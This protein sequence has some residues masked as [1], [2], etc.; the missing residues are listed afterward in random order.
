RAVDGA[1]THDVVRP[2]HPDRQHRS[3]W[4]DVD[5]TVAIIRIAL[6]IFDVDDAP[7]E[8]DARRGTLSS[9]RDG[10]PIEKGRLVSRDRVG[11][12]HPELTTIEAPDQS[13][14]GLAQA[15]RAL[16]QRVEHRLQI[17]RRPSD[18]LEELA[19]RRLLL[20]RDSQL[21]VAGLQLFEQADVLYRDDRL[22]CEDLDEL[23][24][25]R[26]ERLHLTSA[27]SDRADPPAVA[28][29][30]NSEIRPVGGRPL[31]HL[32]RMGIIVGVGADVLDMHGA[33]V[34]ESSAND[35]M[36]ARS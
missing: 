1:V 32:E 19:G 7:L 5:D 6:D 10:V 13:V 15:N 27:T 8:G 22:I 20:E 31:E 35:E 12:H 23:D 30:G 16:R 3:E 24:L 11:S 26:G 4:A 2:E 25:R 18:D 17:G 9:G 21:A 36:A 29:D 34:D 14:L 28:E 33:A